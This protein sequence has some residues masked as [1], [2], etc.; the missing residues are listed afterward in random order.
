EAGEAIRP[1]AWFG[2]D[3]DGAQDGEPVFIVGNPG[4]TSR[5]YAVSQI[6]YEKYRRHPYVVQYL[7]DYVELLRWI[8]SMGPEAERSVREQ[9]ANFENSLKAYS[10]QLEGLQDTVLVGRKIR[11]EADLRAAVQADPGLRAEYGDVWD[12]L[13]AIQADKV[14]VAQRMSIY[15]I[16][17]IGDPQLGL[18]GQLIRYIRE[19]GKPAD[20]RMEGYGAEDLATMEERLLGPSPVNPEIA[21]RLLAVRLRLARNFLPAD[22]PFVQAA[23]QGDETTPPAGSPGTPGSWTPSSAGG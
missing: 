19:S 7:T 13:A 20:E 12:A 17:F 1:E 22:D 9:L 16:G 18:G 5:L 2:W 4:S 11:W 14:P 3:E 6:M 15:N 23:F 10:G 8:G 21:T